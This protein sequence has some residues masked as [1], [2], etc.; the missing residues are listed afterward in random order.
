MRRAEGLRR[1]HNKVGAQSNIGLYCKEAAA[2][3]GTPGDHSVAW[4]INTPP[5]LC[6][7][8]G[9]AFQSPQ[10]TTGRCVQT[11]GGRIY[12]KGDISLSGACPKPR[13]CG[14]VVLL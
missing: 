6:T 4:G 1:E 3:I 7:E 11:I 12:T 2:F 13:W 14:D 5:S 10:G 8:K 9:S